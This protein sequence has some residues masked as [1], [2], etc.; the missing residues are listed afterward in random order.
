M[1]SRAAWF[2]EP[3]LNERGLRVIGWNILQHYY[4]YYYYYYT[5][6]S[7]NFLTKSKLVVLGVPQKAENKHIPQRQF[8]IFSSG[9]SDRAI[10]ATGF[11]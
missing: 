11:A 5:Y 8:A 7:G 10:R 9:E 3:F 6:C 1:A 4:Y 2:C